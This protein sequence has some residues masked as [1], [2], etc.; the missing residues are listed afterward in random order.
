MCSRQSSA[1]RERSHSEVAPALEGRNAAAWGH[2]P[3]QTGGPMSSTSDKKRNN[4]AQLAQELGS[5]GLWSEACMPASRTPSTFPTRHAATSSEQRE[6]VDN[7]H[8]AMAQPQQ[9]LDPPPAYSNLPQVQELPATP[10]NTVPRTGS[11]ARAEREIANSACADPEQNED[12][13]EQ[14]QDVRAP[15]LGHVRRRWNQR[16]HGHWIH[17]GKT[18]RQRHCRLLALVIAS[19]VIAS[20]IVCALTDGFNEVGILS[21]GL[22]ETRRLYTCWRPPLGDP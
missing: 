1:E 14:E 20:I 21:F 15:L 6:Q 3:L 10:V 19:S 5:S 22:P 17:G 18:G 9:D 11:T 12:L 13:E 8:T 16:G 4:A 7:L 2:S